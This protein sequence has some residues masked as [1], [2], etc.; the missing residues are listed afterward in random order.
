M[1]GKADDDEDVNVPR[2]NASVRGDAAELVAH[3]MEAEMRELLGE[4]RGCL[5]WPAVD[6]LTKVRGWLR[7]LWKC[8]EGVP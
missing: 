4:A 6:R 3:Y 1:K 5:G 2:T 8:L 7:G